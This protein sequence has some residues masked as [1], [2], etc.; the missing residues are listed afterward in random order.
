MYDVS[1]LN[2]S[3]VS[4][5]VKDGEAIICQGLWGAQIICDGGAYPAPELDTGLH[6]AVIQNIIRT[7]YNV[8][9][10]VNKT[11]DYR[12]CCALSLTSINITAIVIII[13]IIIVKNNV[14][15]RLLAA[16]N[17]RKAVMRVQTC[18]GITSVLKDT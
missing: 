6:T 13:I 18:C 1:D 14:L 12:Y 8:R 3:N 17:T 5:C 15:L 7:V 2:V 11:L 10:H 4:D 9:S 16:D